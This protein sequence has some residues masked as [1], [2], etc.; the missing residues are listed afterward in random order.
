VHEEVQCKGPMEQQ[1]CVFVVFACV[2]SRNGDLLLR[3][4]GKF[5]ERHMEPN[6]ISRTRMVWLG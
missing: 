1:R 5:V 2:D 3:Q 4:K 6:T